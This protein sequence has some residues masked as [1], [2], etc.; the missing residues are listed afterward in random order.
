M[1]LGYWKQ[2]L[3]HP[4]VVSDHVLNTRLYYIEWGGRV[5]RPLHR[6]HLIYYT[7]PFI[8]TRQ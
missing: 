7:S 1:Y 4:Y 5:K 3:Q 8:P 6:D 2:S